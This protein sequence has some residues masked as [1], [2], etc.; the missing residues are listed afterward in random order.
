VHQRVGSAFVI[1]DESDEQEMIRFVGWEVHIFCPAAHASI[2]HL[3]C[4]GFVQVVLLNGNETY[5]NIH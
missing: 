2:C 5:L 1:K 3:K 4:F